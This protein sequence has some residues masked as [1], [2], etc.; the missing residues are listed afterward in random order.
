MIAVFPIVVSLVRLCMAMDFAA[1][2]MVVLVAN[3]SV[4]MHVERRHC[5]ERQREAHREDQ[6]E[7][8][9]LWPSCR[10]SPP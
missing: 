9:Q 10:R 6:S 4:Q 3:V 1:V 5:V 8:Q 2:V 7:A